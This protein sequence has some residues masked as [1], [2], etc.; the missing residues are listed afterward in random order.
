[1]VSARQSIVFAILDNARMLAAR[2]LALA[3]A[4]T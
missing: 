2:P 4:Q 3:F 1:M